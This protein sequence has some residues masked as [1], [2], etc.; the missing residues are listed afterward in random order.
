[1][2]T[3]QVPKEEFDKL[4]REVRE[5]EERLELLADKELMEQLVQSEADIKAGRVHKL[6]NVRKEL[7]GKD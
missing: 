7:L 2:E 5:L 3:I 4:K 6:E 1:M